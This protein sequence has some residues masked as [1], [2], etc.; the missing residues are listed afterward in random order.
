MAAYVSDT[1][2]DAALNYVQLR[3]TRL[4]LCSTAPTTYAEAT[5]TYMLAQST[6]ALTSTD[7]TVGAGDT[8]G[9]KLTCPV[10]SS[11][12]VTTTGTPVV[13][14]LTGSSGSTL[15][16]YAPC[17]TTQTLTTGN[18][19]NTTAWDWEIRDAST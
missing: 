1:I 12:S 3:A 5:S 19:V 4:N 15:L 2:M 18:T 14:A 11:M 17:T 6:D 16:V 9:R 8:S 13:A 7:L 10:Q